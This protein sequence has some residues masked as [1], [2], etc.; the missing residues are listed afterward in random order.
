MNPVPDFREQR[1]ESIARQFGWVKRVDET[2][3]KVHSQSGDF[4]YDVMQGELGWL[5]SCP[6]AIYRLM[7]C[8]HIHAVELSF[9][10]RK[11]IARQPLVIQPVSVKDC[12]YCKS[13]AIIKKSV[14]HNQSGDIQRF[15]CK[16][17]GK[18]FSFNLGFEGMRATP[19]V[20]TSAMQLYFTG[21]S[22][23]NVQKF[24]RLQG[25]TFSH[26]AVYS[27]VA[28]YTKL[29]ESYLDKLTPQLSDTWRADELFVKIKGDMKYLFAMMDDETRF[30]IAQQITDTKF[31]ADVRP[32]F[33]EG[34]RVAGKKPLTL[35]TDG[36]RHF[37]QPFVKE[38][39]QSKSPHS[40]HVRDIR[41]DGTVHN[42]KMERMNGEVR[43]REKVMRSLKRTDT[44]ILKGYQIFHNYF[45]PHEALNGET[46]AD[47]AGIKV[48]GENKWLT[49]I[50]NA[51]K[52]GKQGRGSGFGKNID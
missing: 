13:E 28:K 17:C 47:R 51:S 18:R 48:E 25:A 16:G 36:G 22:F 45:R 39:Y 14:R 6:D 38:F 20:I 23:R 27:W 42:N 30:W 44:P 8:K 43:D 9:I 29:M 4:E 50:Q 46:P 37:I 40:Q 35:I 11:I 19:Q 10:L 31:T 2:S 5:C 49:L 1:G 24:L 34:K 12:P 3:Y 41:L 32:L 7:K 26:Q 33:A 52:K 15:F 21:E